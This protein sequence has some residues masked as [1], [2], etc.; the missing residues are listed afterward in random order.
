MSEVTRDRQVTCNNH[1]RQ[2][3]PPSH[4]INEVASDDTNQSAHSSQ[5]ALACASKQHCQITSKSAV[6]QTHDPCDSHRL[7]R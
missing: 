6:R 3:A 1:D 7:F 5:L 4:E 2:V